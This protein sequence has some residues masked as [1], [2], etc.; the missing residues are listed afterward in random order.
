ML[1]PSARRILS[2]ASSLCFFLSAQA[3]LAQS[4]NSNA[5]GNGKGNAFGHGN[6]NPFL[7]TPEIDASSGALAIASIV[8][9][10]ALAYVAHRRRAKSSKPTEK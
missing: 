4:A 2:V 1:A 7:S 5:G 9:L 6:G 8:A 10:L 3:G